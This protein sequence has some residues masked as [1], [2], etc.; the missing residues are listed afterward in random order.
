[1]L[2][3][4][5]HRSRWTPTYVSTLHDGDNQAEIQRIQREH[6]GEREACKDNRVIAF[7]GPTRCEHPIRRC[8]SGR[9]ADNHARSLKRLE[10]PGSSSI[11]AIRNARCSSIARNGSWIGQKRS[12]LASRVRHTY[13]ACQTCGIFTCRG[14][15]PG[16]RPGMH[17]FCVQMAFLICTTPVS[18]RAPRWSRI[19]RRRSVTPSMRGATMPPSCSCATLSAAMM[20]DP[21]RRT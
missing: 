1:M 14:L 6:P 3:T 19:G 18:T 5:H 7:L 13:Q 15:P 4:R 11:A 21:C 20:C 12:S 17:C 8:I 2:A 9:A 10:I 16:A